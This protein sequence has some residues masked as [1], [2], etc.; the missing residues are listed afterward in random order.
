MNKPFQQR[1]RV[2]KVI[3]RVPQ[4]IYE[5]TD[6]KDRPIECQLYN[7]EIGKVTVSPQ[8]D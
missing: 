6:L 5:L 1:F 2:A 4:P 7:Y 8:T 3:Q